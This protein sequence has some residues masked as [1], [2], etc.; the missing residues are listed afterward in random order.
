MAKMAKKN[1]RKI[2]T[3]NR[4]GIDLKNVRINLR[5]DGTKLIVFSGLRTR[6]VLKAFKPSFSLILIRDV[7]LIIIGKSLMY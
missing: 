3:F 4:P 2:Q 6:I 7:I 1:D 5:I